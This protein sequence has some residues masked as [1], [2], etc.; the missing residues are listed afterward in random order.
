MTRIL[1]ATF[2]VA[3]APALALAQ[4]QA[5]DTKSTKHTASSA[6]HKHVA[7]KKA[8]KAAPKK[9]EDAGIALTPAEVEEAK[10]VYVGDIKCEL[11]EVVHITADKREGFFEV[12]AGKQHFRMHP[13]ESRTGA[14]R[15][16]DPKAGAMWL[17]LANKS[18]LMNQKLGRRLADECMSPEQ[19]AYAQQMKD[20]PPI[21]IFEPARAAAPASA[22]SQ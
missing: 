18:M 17:Q 15:L 3:L 2:V 19:A 22:A 12:R 5:P 10:K 21:N 14:I 4:A 6:A 20:K 7:K 1:F 8:A 9:D 16:E 11:G 13:V